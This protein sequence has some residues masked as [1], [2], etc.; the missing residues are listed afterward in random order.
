[1]AFSSIEDMP[2]N[3]K[4]GTSTL[5]LPEDDS[6]TLSDNRLEEE[7]EED[8]PTWIRLTTRE[9]AAQGGGED[10][11]QKSRMSPPTT[12]GGFIKRNPLP[13][14]TLRLPRSEKQLNSSFWHQ[15]EAP[16]IKKLER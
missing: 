3:N 16:R 9:R 7:E 13:D 6:K 4:L 8:I 14:M 1:M 15:G 10:K 11:E 12:S 2:L 5:G